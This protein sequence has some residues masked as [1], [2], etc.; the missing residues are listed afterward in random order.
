MIALFVVIGKELVQFLNHNLRQGVDLF[1]LGLCGFPLPLLPRSINL[2]EYGHEL[3]HQ[4]VRD[5]HLLHEVREGVCV[6]R[7]PSDSRFT[8]SLKLV[9]RV[10]LYLLLIPLD[11]IL[12]S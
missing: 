7:K 12:L 6:I 8:L 3:L 5:L 10:I 4:R 1:L 11:N 9:I 2:L